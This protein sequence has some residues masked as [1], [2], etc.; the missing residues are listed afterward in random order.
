[1]AVCMNKKEKSEKG[2]ISM[3]ACAMKPKLPFVTRNEL[4]RTPANEENRKWLSS[5]ILIIFLFLLAR[6]QKS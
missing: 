6:I 5:W 3:N 2:E 4:K 1:M